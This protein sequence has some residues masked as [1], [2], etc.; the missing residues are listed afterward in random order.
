MTF[1]KNLHALHIFLKRGYKACFTILVGCCSPIG[2]MLQTC[3]IYMIMMAYSTNI[4][5]YLSVCS[6]Q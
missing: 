4:L 6:E 1:Y 3:I 5:K 2:T